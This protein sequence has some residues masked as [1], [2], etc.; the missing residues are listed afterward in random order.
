MNG[1]IKVS[2]IVLYAIPLR[3]RSSRTLHHFEETL[4][5]PICWVV[6]PNHLHVILVLHPEASLEKESSSWKSWTTRKINA[7][8]GR[9]GTRWQKDYFDRLVRDTGH[10]GNCVRYIRK[11]PVKA[12]L[13]PGEF[14]LWESDLARGIT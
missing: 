14:L 2:T 12:G 4:C 8:T 3:R 9:S 6:M 13:Q 1:W 5:L 10:F 7:L 11:N